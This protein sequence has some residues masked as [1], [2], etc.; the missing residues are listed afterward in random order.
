[1]G[2][3]AHPWTPG[4]VFL[5]SAQLIPVHVPPPLQAADQTDA[6]N[7]SQ[8]G[9]KKKEKEKESLTGVHAKTVKT[10]DGGRRRS[11]PSQGHFSAKLC[12]PLKIKEKY[13]E[14]II[15][16]LSTTV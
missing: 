1:M 16:S 8:Q 10:K 11:D 15:S 14:D 5:I 4:L 6:A 7:A 12:R 3:T 9:S 13:Y 2:L